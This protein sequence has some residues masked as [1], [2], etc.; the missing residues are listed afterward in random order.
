MC[1]IASIFHVLTRFR[2]ATFMLQTFQT[3]SKVP[4]G[5]GSILSDAVGVDGL[6]LSSKPSAVIALDGLKPY[7]CNK[8]SFETFDVISV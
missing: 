1:Y 5:H 6:T 2:A 3:M 4:L 7:Y 8:F